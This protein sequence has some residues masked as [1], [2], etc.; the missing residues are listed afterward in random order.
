MIGLDQYYQILNLPNNA[1]KEDIKNGYRKLA[2]KWHPD[3]FIDDINQQ[4]LATKKFIEINEA[5]EILINEANYIPSLENSLNVKNVQFNHEK[6][7]DNFAKNYYTLGILSVEDEEWEEAIY[8]FNQAIKINNKFAEAY[9][10]RA[11]ILEK[12]GFNLRAEA[13][14]NQ[15]NKIKKKPNKKRY[16]TVKNQKKYNIKN[17]LSIK[18]MLIIMFGIGLFLFILLGLLLS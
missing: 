13:D 10:Y 7:N 16:Y 18:N 2:K 3:N 15:F 9:F 5:Y 8:Y 17:R 6:Q 4:N 11:T 1:S 14:Y 12:L